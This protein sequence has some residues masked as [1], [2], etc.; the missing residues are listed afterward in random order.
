MPSFAPN[1]E[2]GMVIIMAKQIKIHRS[3]LIFVV[4]LLLSAIIFFVGLRLFSARDSA[5]TAVVTING[6]ESLYV[7]L[8]SDTSEFID[9]YPE[10]GVAVVLE[11]TDH[12]IRF[13]QSD[14]PDHLCIGFGF[15][16]QALEG[17]ACIPN[18]VSVNIRPSK[19]V[20][21]SETLS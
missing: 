9:L 13:V 8:S 17:A 2:Q 10:F 6:K 11:V 12:Q 1:I 7:D 21:Q 15:Q 3:E 18:R 19:E 5:L 4:I 14:C 16:D 20:S